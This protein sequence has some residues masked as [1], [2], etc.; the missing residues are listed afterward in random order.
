MNVQVQTEEKA[1]RGNCVVNMT[2]VKSEDEK[3][4]D[5]QRDA[6]VNETRRIDKHAS[7]CCRVRQPADNLSQYEKDKGRQEPDKHGRTLMDPS[8]GAF[9]N[10]IRINSL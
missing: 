3:D 4:Q 9:Q 8:S 1:A 5:D 10:G 6:T 7:T 2:V